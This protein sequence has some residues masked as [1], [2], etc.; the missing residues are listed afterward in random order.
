MS[1]G[2]GLEPVLDFHLDR[3]LDVR[4][5]LRDL[6]ELARCMDREE[7]DLVHVHQSHDHAVAGFAVRRSRRRPRIVRTNHKGT[8]LR[9][10]LGNRV[11]L[12]RMTDG[13]LTFSAGGLEADRRAFRLPESTSFRI[14][15]SVDLR[16]FDPARTKGDGR[17]AFGFARGQVVVAVVARMQRHRRIEVILEGLARARREAPELRGLF[18]GRGTHR[19]TVA[20]EPARRLGLAEAVVFPGYLGAPR[21][22]VAPGRDPYVEALSAID[23]MVLLV[24]GSDGTCRA[25]REAMA[26]GK[27]PVVSRRGLLPELVEDGR[28]GLVVDETPAGVADALVRLARNPEL[29]LALGLRARQEAR[30]RFETEAQGRVV[31][32]AYR[33]ILDGAPDGRPEAR[34]AAGKGAGRG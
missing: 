32:D 26:M 7:I 9:R 10:T 23:A 28:T 18:I 8:A 16:R 21:G 27:V 33:R 14:P 22:D 25:V 1:R 5:N 11:L 20:V 24:P 13:Y 17:A 4:K 34:A 31:S 30:E 29:R 2:R 19:E 15:V 6:R 12:R 3:Y